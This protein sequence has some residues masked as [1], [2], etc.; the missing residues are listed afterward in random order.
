MKQYSFRFFPAT[1]VVLL[2]CSAMLIPACGNGKKNGQGVFPE[3]FNNKTDREKVVYMMENASP[4]SVARF[5][6]LAAL[7]KIPGVKIDTV[8]MATLYAYENYTD[9]TLAR[10]SSEYDQFVNGLNLADRMR[11]Y[12]M[13]GE[14]DP[15]GLGYDLGLHYVDQIR[16]K[17]MN[18]KDVKTEIEAFRKAC[19]DDPE[20]FTRFLVGFKTVL[21]VDKGKDLSQEIYDTFINYE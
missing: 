11:F 3:G 13:A 16:E 1:L 10:F 18:A 12:K 21:N 5:I 7:G 17:K 19:A 20:T 6:C 2:L 9:T 8:A 15:Q 4:D 14:I